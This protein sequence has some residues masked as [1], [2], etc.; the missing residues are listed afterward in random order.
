RPPPHPPPPPPTR[1]RPPA[2]AAT[3]TDRAT[4]PAPGQR[5]PAGLDGR[6]RRRPRHPLAASHPHPLRAH[7]HRGPDQHA[8][9]VVR[10]IRPPTRPPDPGPR[11]PHGPLLRPRADHPRPR[12]PPPPP[13]P[14]V[15]PPP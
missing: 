13:P 1:G 10:D 2:P 5:R 7:H 9:P 8:V 6:T 15:P 12:P 11:T 4:R 3:T 14:P